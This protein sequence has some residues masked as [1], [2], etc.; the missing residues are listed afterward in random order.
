MII[1]YARRAVTDLDRISDYYFSS[2]N[3]RTAAR[4]EARLL[5]VVQRI[6]KRPES[7]RPVADR[8]GVR[9]ALLTPFPYKVYYRIVAADRIRILHIRHMSRA[10]LE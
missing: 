4:F 2:A 10:P 3:A 5:S 9:I 8:P 6:A 7:A 1:E